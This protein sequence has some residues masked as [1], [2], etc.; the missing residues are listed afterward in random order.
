MKKI[1]LG[2]LLLLVAAW[3]GATW[4]IGKGV[5]EGVQ[6]FYEQAEL[7]MAESG[8][9]R[10]KLEGGG[11]EGGF[12]SSTATTDLKLDMPPFNQGEGEADKLTFNTKIYHGPVMFTPDGVKIGSVY[13]VSTLDLSQF[14]EKF[15][16]FVAKGFDDETPVKIAAL[17][18]FGGA[19]DSTATM[20]L[21]RHIKEEADGSTSIID[22]AGFNA[23]AHGTTEAGSAVS[24][25]FKIGEFNIKNETRKKTLTI[26]ASEGEV[27]IEEVVDGIALASSSKFTVPEIKSSDEAK[28]YS[29]KDVTLR[30]ESTA[31][32]S[33]NTISGLG[34]IE[35]GSASGGEPGGMT[36]GLVKQ[37]GDG[38][39]IEFEFKGWNLEALQD[40]QKNLSES[41]ELQVELA[42]RKVAGDADT[43]KLEAEIEKN[44][45]AGAE[46]LLSLFRP[47][48][49]WD[50]RT[51][52]GDG[53][54]RTDLQL[55]I[56]YAKGAI[57]MA[58][59]TTLR[60]I[61]KG[62]EVTIDLRLAKAILPEGLGEMMLAPQVESGMIEDRGDYYRGSAELKDAKVVVNGNEMPLLQ[63]VEPYM[64]D[65]EFFRGI[66]AG[67]QSGLNSKMGQPAGAGPGGANMNAPVVPGA[68]DAPSSNPAPDAAPEPQPQSE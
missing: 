7:Q 8:E 1:I 27:D 35:I 37:L 25:S 32:V 26:S 22:F 11:I 59:A 54:T 38:G 42:K 66:K 47:G 21:F 50:L 18:G 16:E 39:Y 68:S 56:G 40:I 30:S 61:V 4:L 17:F 29:I 58:E 36:T 5:D 9:K 15:Q 13:S 45:A 60:P 23:E 10:V 41:S 51:K 46:S 64:D 24:G 31:D 67:M 57:P 52:V 3:A 6:S 63:M 12:L 48:F 19:V 65:E 34:R 33:D 2:V 62:L 14:P 20:P 53:E 49:S 28:Q 43:A 55:G 44:N